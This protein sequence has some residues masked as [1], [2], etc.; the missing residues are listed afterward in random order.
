MKRLTVEVDVNGV[1]SDKEVA[2]DILLCL[3]DVGEEGR[4]DSFAGGELISL[5]RI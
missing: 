4:D 2:E 3:W 5:A 1:K